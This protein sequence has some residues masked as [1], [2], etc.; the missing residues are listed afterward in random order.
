MVRLA[1]LATVAAARRR[2]ARQPHA[3]RAL[4]GIHIDPL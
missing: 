1:T 4:L 2:H 3:A